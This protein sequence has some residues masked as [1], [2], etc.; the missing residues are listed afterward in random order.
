[1]HLATVHDACDRATDGARAIMRDEPEV[2]AAGQW[3][4]VADDNGTVVGTVPFETLAGAQCRTSN[5][6]G[7]ATGS[8]ISFAVEATSLDP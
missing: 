1:M 8:E 2:P 7:V 3:V 6:E 4:E 5:C